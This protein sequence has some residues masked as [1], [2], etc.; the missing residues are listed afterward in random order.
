MRNRSVT[1]ALGVAA[2]LSMSACLA[3]GSGGL[4]DPATAGPA[5]ARR[6]G[7]A[8]AGGRTVA[9]QTIDP[10]D[11]IVVHGPY[12]TLTRDNALAFHEALQFAL[13]QA[14]HARAAAEVPSH[15]VLEELAERYPRASRD[16]QL[17]LAGWR[18]IWTAMRMRWSDLSPA[19]QRAFVRAMLVASFGAEA[20][21]KLDGASAGDRVAAADSSGDDDA[22]TPAFDYP[23]S[24]CWSSAGCRL[25][26]VSGDRTTRSF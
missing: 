24:G 14:G 23:G 7:K 13:A 8:R 4:A 18:A 12:A 16:D 19:D 6:T 9:A 1:A 3:A 17:A 25:G 22:L 10:T 21:G 26:A 20:A 2:A 11:P 15:R 5:E